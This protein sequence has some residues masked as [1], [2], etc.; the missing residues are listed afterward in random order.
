MGAVLPGASSNVSLGTGLTKA[1]LRLLGGPDLADAVADLAGLER[2]SVRALAESAG[3]TLTADAGHEFTQLGGDTARTAAEELVVE[4]FSSLAGSLRPAD[5]RAFAVA[6]LMGSEGLVRLLLEQL[7][8]TRLDGWSPDESLYFYALL[9]RTVELTVA[10]YEKTPTARSYATGMGVGQLLRHAED[11][12][13][14]LDRLEHGLEALTSTAVEIPSTWVRTG[15]PGAAARIVVIA[16][17]RQERRPALVRFAQWV[18]WSLVE[19]GFPVHEGPPSGRP[20]EVCLLVSSLDNPDA[21]DRVDASTTVI[22]LSF[23]EDGRLVVEGRSAS[24]GNAAELLADVVGPLVQGRTL[25]GTDGLGYDETTSLHRLRR[26]SEQALVEAGAVGRHTLA[27]SDDAPGLYVRRDLEERVLAELDAR[28]LVVVAGPAGVGKTS[29]LWGLAQRLVR[30]SG[31]DVYFLKASF[32]VDAEGREALVSAS[33]LARAIRARSLEADSVVLVDTV[34]LLVNDA[35]SL[36]TLTSFVDEVTAAGARLVITSRPAEAEVISAGGDAPL[37]LGSF[38]TTDR[39]GTEPEFARAVRSH[40]VGYCTTPGDTGELA[41]QLLLSAVRGAPAGELARLPLSMRLLFELYAPGP[42]PPEVSPSGLFAQFWDHRVERDRRSWTVQPEPQ[43]DQDLSST[44]TALAAQ[45]LRTGLPEAGI[46]PA[47]SASPLPGATSEAVELLCRRGVGSVTEQGRFRFFHQAFFEHVAARWLAGRP[48]GLTVLANR[49]VEHPDDH[50]VAAVLEQCWVLAWN[51]PRRIGEA[52]DRALERLDGRPVDIRLVLRVLAQVRVP[53]SL[54]ERLHGL[55]AEADLDIV[56]EYLRLLPR[57]GLD[58]QQADAGLLATV[59]SRGGGTAGTAVFDVLLRLARGD[60]ATARFVVDTVASASSEP[61]FGDK[62]L[63]RSEPVALVAVLA[64]DDAAWVLHLLDRSG[65]GTTLASDSSRLARLLGALRASPVREA[66]SVARWAARLLDGR[67]AESATLVAALRDLLAVALAAEPADQL[68]A[69]FADCLHA[70]SERTQ[71]TAVGSATC[72][73]TLD[74]L[75]ARGSDAPVV[76]VLSLLLARPE[77]W[78]HEQVH[79]GWLVRAVNQ[80]PMVRSVLAAALADGLPASHRSPAG[81]SQYWAD[82][83]RRLLARDDVDDRARLEVLARQRLLSAGRERTGEP[84]ADDLQLAWLFLLAANAGDPSA[85]EALRR[86]G[87][88]ELTMPQ[89]TERIVLQQAQQLSGP[90]PGT[91]LVLSTLL[92]RRA[93][94][95]LLQ[96]MRRLPKEVWPPEV[97][98]DPGLVVD[99]SY[100]DAPR[101]AQALRLLVEVTG[102]G[103]AYPTWPQLQ[104]LLHTRDRSLRLGLSSL[105]LGGLEQGAYAANPVLTRLNEWLAEDPTLREVRRALVRACSIVG[106]EATVQVSLQLAFTPPVESGTVDEL[107]GYLHQAARRGPPLSTTAALGLLL[108]VGRRLREPDVGR[109]VRQDV[110]RMW[111]DVMGQVLNRASASELVEVV[112]AVPEL[113]AHF[114]DRMLRRLP[115]R[116]DP[117]VRA[118]LTA[119]ANGGGVD[120]RVARAA[121]QRLAHTAAPVVNDWPDLDLLVAGSPTGG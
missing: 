39:P 78:V 79:R 48:G 114:A 25:T 75:A 86:W 15:G 61:L 14:R 100:G 6:A 10:W 3:E 63:D 33:D 95:E 72:W 68:V 94:V 59:H 66:P 26:L 87:H 77:P 46:G 42:V 69:G 60:A 35:R 21:P 18:R 65:I 118:V 32:L 107:A 30:E 113:G 11:S 4:L 89:V 102:R 111:S 112:T 20:D 117:E 51:D 16:D 9:H 44:C 45:M 47:M 53:T 83:V 106:D 76:E 116:G 91:T 7:T 121:H 23:G 49:V 58:W 101:R 62:A 109:R 13:R 84:W 88:G 74:V 119:L 93:H 29:L 57:P 64:R 97:I 73:A 71:V 90:G 55:L 81:V 92:T 82:T 52:T 120:A 37:L 98:N 27:P 103:A 50:F 104:P 41:H 1:A 43:D 24:A 99:A 22:T 115:A 8:P 85:T 105:L 67:S 28:S 17:P 54:V 12:E 19:Y 36:D 110:P 2:K 31:P 5:P 96:L 70:M 38:S 40:A 80:S 108:D 34:D 56:K